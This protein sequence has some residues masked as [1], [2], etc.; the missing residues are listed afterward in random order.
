LYIHTKLKQKQ[1]KNGLKF[2]LTTVAEFSEAKTASLLIK[3]PF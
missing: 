2:K 3:D 1:S